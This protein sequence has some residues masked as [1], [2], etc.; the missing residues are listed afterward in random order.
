VVVYVDEIIFGSNL[1]IMSRKFA[2]KMQDELEMSMLGELSL[3]LGLQVTQSEKG[4]F[5]SKTKYIKEMLKK[6]QMEDSK[7]IS[8]PMVTGC[9]VSLDDVSQKVDKTMYRSMIESFLYST[10]T[11][12]DI[13][14][15]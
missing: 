2:T 15:V 10:T 1:T 5:I 12:P 8:T 6:F 7:P 9:K 11:R 3:F 13:M 4:I 14:Q